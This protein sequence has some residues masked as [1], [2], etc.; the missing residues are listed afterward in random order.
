MKKI[1]I[2]LMILIVCAGFMHEVMKSDD[3]EV[4]NGPLLEADKVLVIKSERK[5]HLLKEGVI[6]RTYSIALGDNPVGHKEQKGDERTPE[7]KYILDWRNPNSMCYKSIHISYPNKQDRLRAKKKGV[8]PGGDIMIH[9]I[10]NGY[11]WVG[12]D[13]IK[14]DW[15]DGCVAVSDKEMDEIWTSVKNGTPI[16]IKP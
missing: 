11:G 10:L 6:F 15:T 2:L 14:Q 13:H 16:E 5:I 3:P 1:V 9:G 4:N 12:K 7:G 8:S